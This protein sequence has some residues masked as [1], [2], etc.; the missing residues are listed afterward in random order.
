VAYPRLHHVGIVVPSEEQVLSLM[1]L[2]GLEEEHRGFVE[3]YAANCIFTT[4]AEGASR[5][6]FVV[7]EGGVL[8]EFN[9]GAGGLHHVALL[10]DSLES[11]ASDLRQRGIEFLETEPVRGAGD[12]ICNFL[13][14]THTRGVIVEFV[15][16]L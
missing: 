9:R 13:E 12:F 8:A 16:A 5:I 7:P 3:R 15:E 4:A 14:P 1:Q 11:T 6:E 10:V 2:L